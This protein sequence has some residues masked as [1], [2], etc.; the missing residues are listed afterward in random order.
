MDYVNIIVDISHE[1]VDRVFQYR[2]PEALRDH[3]Q[4][5][6]QVE[7]P[8]GRGNR[9]TKGYV[10]GLTDRPDYPPEKIKELQGVVK[11]SVKAESQLI[12]LAAWMRER[13][14][15]TMNHALKTVLPVKQKTRQKQSKKIKPNRKKKTN[16]N[17][18][19]FLR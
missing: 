4:V 2:V 12:A 11:G 9:L 18:V 10:V 13:Y 19:N 1:K 15:S 7:A 16:N 6:M 17:A 8:F 3:L 14:G 5:G